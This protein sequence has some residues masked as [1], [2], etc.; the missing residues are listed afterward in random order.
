MPSLTKDVTVAAN[1]VKSTVV[2]PLEHQILKSA[3]VLDIEAALQPNDAYV[4]IGLMEGGLS[5][6]NKVCILASGYVGASSMIGWTGSMPITVDTHVFADIYSAA[7]G[8][9]R[10]VALPWKIVSTKDGLFVV[11]P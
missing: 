7:G 4:T 5:H 9:F 11:D 1:R 2:I 6:Q 10:L 8:D 3:C